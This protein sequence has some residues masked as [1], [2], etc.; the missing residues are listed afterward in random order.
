MKLIGVFGKNRREWVIL[1]IANIL[2]GYTMVPF[3]DTLGKISSYL[4]LGP[5]SI[6]F[7]LNQTNIETMF[8]SGDATKSL[9]K[10][11]EKGK[12]LNL[13]LFDL[14][15]EDLERVILFVQIRN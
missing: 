8:I 2:Y 6:P 14:L 5:D 15:T 12:L 13:V 9:L 11:K 7:I 1:D 4:Y 3:Y 10:C